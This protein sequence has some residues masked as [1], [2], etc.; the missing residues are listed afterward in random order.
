MYSGDEVYDDDVTS[1]PLDE[2]PADVCPSCGAGTDELVELAPCS[3]CG[4]DNTD[5]EN[6]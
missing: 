3:A 1:G 5:E 2:Q 6:R 4:A